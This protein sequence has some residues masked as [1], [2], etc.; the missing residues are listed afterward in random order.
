MKDLRDTL[1]VIIVLGT[2]V[3]NAI[4]IYVLLYDPLSQALVDKN[5]PYYLP[6]SNG[7]IQIITLLI[8]GLLILTSIFLVLKIYKKQKVLLI[9][10]LFTLLIICA[11]FMVSF[12]SPKYPSSI[13]GYEKDG[14]Y[15]KIEIWWNMPNHMTIYKRWKS[16]LPYDGKLSTEQLKYKLDSLSNTKDD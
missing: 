5:Q 15:Y 3:I 8:I 12:T 2:L 14:Y 6:D 10:P 4:L 7:F 16:A 11:L 13:S 1:K 9:A